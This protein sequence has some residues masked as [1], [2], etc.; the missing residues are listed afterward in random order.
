MSYLVNPFGPP[1]PAQDF[2]LNQVYQNVQGTSTDFDMI[3]LPAYQ[4]PDPAYPTLGHPSDQ[5]ISHFGQVD[6]APNYQQEFANALNQ[7]FFQSVYRPELA[8]NGFALSRGIYQGGSVMLMGQA[9]TPAPSPFNNNYVQFVQPNSNL[10]SPGPHEISGCSDPSHEHPHGADRPQDLL[11][12]R[13]EGFDNPGSGGQLGHPSQPPPPSQLTY[14][15]NKIEYPDGN[16]GQIIIELNENQSGPSNPD[17]QASTSV[18]GQVSGPIFSS[19]S[20]SSPASTPPPVSE[21]HHGDYHEHEDELDKHV[22]YPASSAEQTKALASSQ[23]LKMFRQQ[24]DNFKASHGPVAF[25]TAA[26]RC[27][28][29]AKGSRPGKISQP[30]RRHIKKEEAPVNVLPDVMPM[31]LTQLDQTGLFSFGS[32]AWTISFEA[33]PKFKQ[34]FFAG[35]QELFIRFLLP[36]CRCT[37]GSSSRF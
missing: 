18:P 36:A 27:P 25:P 9:T 23:L 8:Q 35:N 26:P 32:Q 3:S 29:L 11:Q 30:Q 34:F 4:L 16:S 22:A 2:A 17:I 6:P 31:D 5:F 12:Y 33:N 37:E 14:F 7:D 24:L 15:I 10:V 1:E 13:W 21:L 28:K 19:Y 20:R